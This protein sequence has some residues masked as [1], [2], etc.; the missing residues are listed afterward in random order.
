LEKAIGIDVGGTKILFVMID[1]QGNVLKKMKCATPSERDELLKTL[2]KGIKKIKGKEKIKGI[3]FGLAG[4]LDSNRGIMRFSP[5]IPCINNLNFKAYL[6]KHFKEKLVFEN[7]ANA[8]ALAEY[9]A[10]YGRKY[11]NMIGI[12][13]GTG[14]GGGIICEGT[15][16][17]G[18]GYGAELGHMIID[19]SSQKRCACGNPGCFEEHSDGKALL[20]KAHEYGLDIKSNL[21][22]SKLLKKGDKRAIGAVKEIAKYLA[23]GLVNIINIFDPEAIVIGGGLSNIDLLIEEAKRQL[24]KYTTVRKDTKILKAK[25][26]DNAAAIGAALLTMEDFLRMEKTPDVAVDAIIEY[27]SHG[28]MKGVVL[29]ERRFEPKGWA[30]PGGLVKYGESAESAVKREAFEETGLKIQSLKQFK[31]YSDPKRDPRR[32]AISI[33]F[34]AKAFGKIRPGSD[35]ADAKVFSINRIPKNL[36][37][38]HNKIIEDWLKERKIKEKLSAVSL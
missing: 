5:N 33:V 10:G 35:A 3:G 23:V 27:H 1:E 6:K 4:F 29:I 9:A 15:L 17:K 8:F 7:D 32:H 16:I 26:N 30:L 38:D 21:E 12:T 28:R 36:C 22:L 11:K 24:A 31:V 19:L 37:F 25:L 2:V 34:S 14:I 13:L 18:R 20:E